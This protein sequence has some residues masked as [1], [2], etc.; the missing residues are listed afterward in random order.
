LHTTM[1]SSGSPK[2]RGG[3][4]EGKEGV[5]G[6]VIKYAGRKGKKGKGRGTKNEVRDIR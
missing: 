3:G 1:P 5:C 6:E 2:F 4:R